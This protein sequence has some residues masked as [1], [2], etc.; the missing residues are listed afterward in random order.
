MAKK[1]S[2]LFITTDEQHI[3][4]VYRS[5]MPY[6]L[7]NLR[8][9]MACSDVYTQVHIPVQCRASGRQYP[10]LRAVCP[11]VPYTVYIV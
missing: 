5:D 9:L 3:D 11:Q 1:P 10:R 4:T 7:P 6:A 2:I 8:G